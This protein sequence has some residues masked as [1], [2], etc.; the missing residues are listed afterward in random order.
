M[1]IAV[2][3]VMSGTL[4]MVLRFMVKKRLLVESAG[5]VS[6]SEHANRP[7]KGETANRVAVP[8]FKAE[9]LNDR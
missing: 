9:A 2:R 7:F 4:L 5:P 6:G 8:A 1:R 3:L